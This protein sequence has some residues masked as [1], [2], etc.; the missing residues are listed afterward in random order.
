MREISKLENCYID[1]LKSSFKALNKLEATV[2]YVQ[3]SLSKKL[4]NTSHFDHD[5][6]NCVQGTVVGSKD[7]SFTPS[8]SNKK[9]ST[10]ISFGAKLT[11]SV[12]AFSLVKT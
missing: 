7:S 2:D 5:N 8:D 4:K 11:K 6:G 10:F 3:L 12:N 9:P 1:D